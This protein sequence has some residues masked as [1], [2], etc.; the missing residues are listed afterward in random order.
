MQINE[1]LRDI[2]S[3]EMEVVHPNERL[4]IVENK[5]A[6]PD[7]LEEDKDKSEKG[8]DESEEDE[9]ISDFIV[10]VGKVNFLTRKSLH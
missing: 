4:E 1:I 3:S 2:P 6:G 7:L 8:K 9:K 10:K 5:D